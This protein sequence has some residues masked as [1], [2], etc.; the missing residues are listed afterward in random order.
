MADLYLLGIDLGTSALKCVAFNAQGDEIA[1]S[2]R[3]PEIMRP[4]PSWSELSMDQLWDTV[5][6][7]V[8]EISSNPVVSSGKIAGIGITGTCCGSWLLDADGNP[9]RNAILWN[10]GRAADIIGRWQQDQILDKIFS[11]SGNVIFPGY[12]V[13]VLRWL[14]EY[15]PHTLERAT[16]NVYC[17]DWL[18]FKLTGNLALDRSDIGYMPSDIQRGEISDELLGVCGIESTKRLF[19]GFIE[20]DAIAGYVLRDVAQA[21]GIP[22]GIPVVGGLVDVAATTLG[23]GAY[24]PGQ[25][26]SIIGTSFLNNIVADRPSFEPFGTGVQTQSVNH[27]WIRSMV[28]TSGTINVQWF[29]DQFYKDELTV[30][31]NPFLT[32]YDWAEFTASQVPIG[33]RGIV[34]HP[35]LNT[36]GVISPFVNPTAR[37]QFF[38][39]SIEHTRADMLRAV[40][41]GTALS[42]LDCF[43]HLPMRLRSCS[44]RAAERAAIFGA[45]CFP[46]VPGL[47]SKYHPARNRVRAG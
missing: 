43:A 17:K 10:D 39:L 6:S 3:T 24:L 20:S 40:Y 29:L 9:V 37:A 1:I 25:A 32:I 15:E 38:G 22:A 16:Y 33:S 19:P 21:L 30:D 34:Y 12:T 28:N 8:R 11:L 23:T 41:E 26:C 18:R 27:V 13:P 36:T 5:R 35:Y 4:K 45:R 7:C 14:L 42:M 2:R 31:H 44:S 46:T 47:P